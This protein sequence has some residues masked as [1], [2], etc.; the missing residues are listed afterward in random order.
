M[1]MIMKGKRVVSEFDQSGHSDVYT[2][3]HVQCSSQNASTSICDLSETNIYNFKLK[4]TNCVHHLQIRLNITL[5]Y[6]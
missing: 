5:F 4:P 2:F 3:A 1:Y 6:F